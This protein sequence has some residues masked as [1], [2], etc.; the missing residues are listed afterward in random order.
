MTLVPLPLRDAART[1]R[2][3]FDWRV[4]FFASAVMAV[5][6]VVAGLAPA[7]RLAQTNAMETLRQQAAARQVRAP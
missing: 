4:A 7:R 6:A 1:G 3:A 5:T 2:T